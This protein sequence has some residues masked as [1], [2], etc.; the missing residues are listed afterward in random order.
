M[1][2]KS[3][4]IIVGLFIILGLV[5]MSYISVELGQVD[6]FKSDDYNLTA[7]FTT[8]TGLKKNTNV[9]ISGVKI[10]TV[11]S[12]ELKDYQA[13][14]TLNID[15]QYKIQDDAIA[16]IRT[17]G[18]LGEQYVEVL[19]GGSGVILKEGEEIFDTE[20]PFELLTLI[21]NLVAGE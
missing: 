2:K 18:L 19:P 3:V 11:Q 15:E 20:P 5:C 14:V 7:T 6:L 9:E 13:L 16:S 1:K 8:A 4:E 17:K 10:G 12:I 21:R